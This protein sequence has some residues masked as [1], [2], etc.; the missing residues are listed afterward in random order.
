VTERS[1]TQSWGPW[2]LQGP[3]CLRHTFVAWAAEAIRHACWAQVSYQQQRDQGKAPQAALRALAFPWS[4]ILYRCWQERTPY[5]EA[6]YLQ[7]LH[8]RGASVIQTLAKA[9]GTTVKTP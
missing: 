1:G 4:R 9:S 2:H 3:T 5:D 7:A 8:R 6:G